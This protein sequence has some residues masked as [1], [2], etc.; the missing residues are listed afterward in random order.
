MQR[1]RKFGWPAPPVVIGLER[2]CPDRDAGLHR[3]PPGCRKIGFFALADVNPGEDWIMRKYLLVAAACLALGAVT[4]SVPVAAQ[5]TGEKTVSPQRQKMK[6]CGA[7][8]KEEK[9]TKN[10]S[11]RA[12]YRAFMK[13]CLKG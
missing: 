2:R 13:D 5:D 12:A 11:G 10:V 6:D 9:A 1:P 7:K 4:M 3:R 8:W